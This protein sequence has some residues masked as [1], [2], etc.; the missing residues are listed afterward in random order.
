VRPALVVDDRDHAGPLAG[1]D[2][3]VDRVGEHHLEGLVRLD[4]RVALDEYGQRHGLLV[5]VER[6]RAGGGCVVAARGGG[7]SLVLYC[8]VTCSWVVLGATA[9]VTLNTTAERPMSYSCVETAR[10]VMETTLVTR[11]M[12]SPRLATVRGPPAPWNAVTEPVPP[13]E[14]V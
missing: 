13:T 8:T 10:L 1:A 14:M 5:D 2:D 3:R 9:S 11:T 4:Q 6:E 12:V 7:P